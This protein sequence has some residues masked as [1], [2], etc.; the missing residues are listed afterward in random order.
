MENLWEQQGQQT[1]WLPGRLGKRNTFLQAGQ[2][3][4]IWVLRS[5]NLFFCRRIVF[6]TPFMHLRKAAFSFCLLYMLRDIDRVMD[7]IKSSNIKAPIT[8][9]S[10]K[11]FTINNPKHKKIRKI[12]RASVPFRPCIKLYSRFLN[13]VFFKIRVL[14]NEMQRANLK[15]R[16]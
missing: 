2:R 7:K 15:V 10:I 5:L 8:G 13:G 16:S 12:Y 9:E 14:S 11:I 6:F 3:L 4:Y 1:L